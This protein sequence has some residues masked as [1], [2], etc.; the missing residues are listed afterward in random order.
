MEECHLFDE[1][2][3]KLRGHYYVKFGNHCSCLRFLNRHLCQNSIFLFYDIF[4]FSLL[5]KSEIR[6]IMSPGCLSV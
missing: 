2:F 3:V 1:A 4:Y 6:C 5:L